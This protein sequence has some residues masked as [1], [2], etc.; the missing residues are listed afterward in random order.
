M[1]ISNLLALLA[2]VA[3]FLFGMSLMGDGLKKVAG[4]KLQT[5]LYKLTNTTLKGILLGT[6]VTAVIQSS[7]A[8]SVLVVGFV[9]SG[10]MKMK[11]AIGIV[12]GAIIGT[13]VTGWIIC[14]STL[15]P[16]AGSGI[17]ELLSTD[18]LTAI[19]AVVGI[20]LHMSS[21]NQTKKYVGDIMLGF[22]VLM[23]GIDSMSAAVYPLRESAAFVGLLTKFSN[24]ILGVLIGVI[25]TSILQSASAAVGILQ[26]LAVT[27]AISFEIALPI[28]MGI[29]IGAS[30]PVLL[31][32][33][34]A[35]TA[36][37]RTALSYLMIDLVGAIVFGILFYG[38]NA[39]AHFGFMGIALNAVHIAAINT[40]FRLVIV[41]LIAPAIT[42]IEKL[43]ILCVPDNPEE[44]AD[45]KDMD[46]LEDRF[47]AYPA[48]AVEQSEQVVNSMVEKTRR[49]I[50]GALGLFDNFDSKVFAKVERG[51]ETIDRY[52]DKLGTYLTK[53]TSLEL[54][55]DQTTKVSKFLHIITDYERISD[56]ALNI[57]ES[58]KEIHDKKIEFSED[59]REDL[60][61]AVAALIEIVDISFDAFVNDDQR[62]AVHIEPLEERIDEL[63]DELKRKHIERLTAGKC[64]LQN[65][66]VF[67]DI[68]TTIERISDHCS[69]IAV[70]IVE[71]DDGS[72]ET[73]RTLAD[74]KNEHK[75][76]YDELLDQYRQKYV[77]K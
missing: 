40:A 24:P 39:F 46:R 70:A 48:V 57:A 60:K 68:V 41:V 2:G 73:H 19:I 15:N 3:L 35:N 22:S 52:E 14:L 12:M 69:N 28:L 1:G 59:A 49:T 10:M 53:L 38:I 67:N 58:A 45:T 33:I 56:H 23:F 66:F 74:L 65:G 44:A 43:V 55:R 32:A 26:T 4:N 20:V 7:S 29:A 37:K 77:V 36:A 64:T 51:E 11:N 13:S 42:L 31:S 30:V 16:G 75:H 47:L 8:T 34:G 54:N 27:G 17:L 25:F 50:Y 63:C 21:K 71:L 18:T 72:F 6:G 61:V 9:N 76:H 5:I 62:T